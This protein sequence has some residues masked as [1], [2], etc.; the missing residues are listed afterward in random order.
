MFGLGATQPI[1]RSMYL[2]VQYGDFSSRSITCSLQKRILPWLRFLTPLC[3]VWG[4]RFMALFRKHVSELTCLTTYILHTFGTIFPPKHYIVTT[5]SLHIH[6]CRFHDVASA[7]AETR[8]RLQGK[9]PKVQSFVCFFECRGALFGSG[10]CCKSSSSSCS[11]R[12]RI[13]IPRLD[14]QPPDSALSRPFCALHSHYI[15]ITVAF[16]LLILL[17]VLLLLLRR[18]QV[19]LLL[20]RRHQYGTLRKTT[21]AP[22][23]LPSWR[24]HR[25]FQIACKRP[26]CTPFGALCHA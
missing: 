10:C 16:F 12:R 1:F 24:R 5:L 13:F 15:N 3:E 8:Q 22:T 21:T 2:Y 17:L 6:H 18:E 20:V 4:S 26:S 7:T 9:V 14:K 19:L 25:Q 11:K 23:S